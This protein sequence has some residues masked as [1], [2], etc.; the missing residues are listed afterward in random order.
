MARVLD[1]GLACPL[2]MAP[3]STLDQ[4]RGSTHIL[5][6]ALELI[7]PNE[8][9][10]RLV[11]NQN[12]NQVLEN[13]SE[14]PVFV[15]TNAFPGVA[16]PLYVYEP[17]YRLLARR[18][19]QST[20]R[21]F[22]MIAKIEGVDAFASYG[23]LLEVKDAVHLHDGRSILTT[24][25]V[26]RFKVLQKGEQDG[27][28]TVK[29]QYIRDSMVS[30]EKLPELLTLHQRVYNKAAKWVNSLTPRVLDEVERSIGKMPELEKDW[31]SLPDGPAWAW[32][33]MPILPLSSQLQVGTIN[34]ITSIL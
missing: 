10:D 17:R 18:C 23:T 6:E 30:A 20:S 22:A 29:V 14:I 1:H 32:W 3:L 31:P 7:A 25:G 19:L 27:Y 13:N 16:C 21:K 33:L 8:Y 5:V 15:C 34:Y 24:V 4:T 2:C 9:A 28:D 11:A 26:S 12:E